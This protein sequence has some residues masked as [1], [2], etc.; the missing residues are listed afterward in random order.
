MLKVIVCLVAFCHSADKAISGTTGA[1]CERAVMRRCNAIF[2]TVWALMFCG[3]QFF[4]GFALCSCGKVLI[5]YTA[6]RPVAL[7]RH[8]QIS[9]DL[10]IS[11]NTLDSLRFI[12]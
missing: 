4:K 8:A 7:S 3:L 6:A 12:C 9:W 11:T 10:D 5:F 1:V 2:E